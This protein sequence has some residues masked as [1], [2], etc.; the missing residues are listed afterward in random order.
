MT[1]YAPISC[2]LSNDGSRV[3]VEI[4]QREVAF[5][6]V[7]EVFVFLST[8]KNTNKFEPPHAFEH[9]VKDKK[10]AVVDTC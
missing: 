9:V 8:E 2:P 4:L 5:D 1:T 3:E 6:I 7:R 10:T